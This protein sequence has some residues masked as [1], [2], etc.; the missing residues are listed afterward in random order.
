M[1]EL[2]ES[3]LEFIEKQI[4]M[5]NNVEIEKTDSEILIKRKII[6]KSKRFPLI[7]RPMFWAGSILIIPVVISTALIYYFMR[8]ERIFG[9]G[10]LSS[11]SKEGVSSGILENLNAQGLSWVPDMINIYD[12][13]AIIF[14]G[15]FLI[16]LLISLILISIDIKLERKKV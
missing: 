2:S 13:R 9:G 8:I 3:E 12:N 5:N 4:S 6:K 15:L 1:R 11:F 10:A 16:F 14:G 7:R